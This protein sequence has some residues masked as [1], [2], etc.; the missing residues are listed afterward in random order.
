MGFFSL[1]SSKKCLMTY[2]IKMSLDNILSVTINPEIPG[3]TNHEYIR[4]W[5]LY[6][7]KIMYN[8]G[9]PNNTTS[10]L[11]CNVLRQIIAIEFD[12]STNCFERAKLSDV[13]SFSNQCFNPKVSFTGEFYAKDSSDRFIKTNFPL[14]ITEQQVLYSSI[15]LLQY[16]TN[17]CSKV[18]EDLDIIRKTI[19]F[20]LSGFDSGPTDIRTMTFLLP[21]KSYILAL[22]TDNK[23][24][25]SEK[26]KHRFNFDNDRLLGFF[27]LIT[28]RDKLS[29]I[30][31]RYRAR[32]YTLNSGSI[33][34][35][36]L[37]SFF[38]IGYN[39]RLAEVMYAGKTVLPVLEVENNKET[40]AF[41]Y[42]NNTKD[43]KIELIAE[44]K[45]QNADTYCL[46]KEVEAYTFLGLDLLNEYFI[47][48]LSD[49]MNEI[50]FIAKTGIPQRDA[51]EVGG[52]NTALG[53]CYRLAEEIVEA[54][55]IF[56]EEIPF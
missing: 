8:L 7:C 30:A 32:K 42:S 50:E 1:F 14:N 51:N 48:I 37:G 23:D 44:Y 12:H 15:G 43:Q 3:L 40:E 54:E 39:I 28:A 21:Q 5:V 2:E 4:L 52:R 36:Y 18:Q 38:T 46:G 22:Q 26:E 34:D 53:Y 20:L 35:E 45:E 33:M 29:E 9:Y 19:F 11:L 49:F 31:K 41:L 56:D 6:Q 17:K 55:E 16:V 47:F 24:I 25:F 27:S 13:I 10:N